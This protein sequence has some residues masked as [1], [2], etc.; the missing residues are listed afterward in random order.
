MG[1][2]ADSSPNIP[3]AHEATA[4]VT[5]TEIT[6]SE[7]PLTEITIEMLENLEYPL[8]YANNGRAKLVEGEFREPAA[9]GS[10]TET[11][12]K[13]SEF[14]SFGE[15]NEEPAAGVIL[16]SDPGGSGTF[17]DLALVVLRDSIPAVLGTAFLG[18]RILVNSIELI[19]EGVVVDLVTQGP[20]DAM[21]SPTQQVTNTYRMMNGQ[22]ELA[23]S[24][25]A[26][27]DL[28]ETGIDPRLMSINWQW[29]RFTDPLQAFDLPDPENYTLKFGE[30]GVVQIKADCNMASGSYAIENSGITIAVG[31]M[32]LA[33]CPPGSLS[34]QFIQDLGFVRIY[35]FQ[36]DYLFLDLMAD[37]GTMQFKN[38]S[39]KP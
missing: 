30:D 29:M 35:F 3:A 25:I 36:D 28:T 11:I 10:A 32:T 20:E 26:E 33:A 19:V 27:D 23:E 21:V 8:E 38:A 16:V 1:A 7:T 12:I 17:Y 5:P 22:L 14:T 34:D 37:G 13:I 24:E 6:L 2:P 31:P 4:T 9:P 18:D 15:L 39:D